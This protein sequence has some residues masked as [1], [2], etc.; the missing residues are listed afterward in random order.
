MNFKIL[1]LLST[2]CTVLFSCTDKNGLEVS[3]YVRYEAEALEN[4][5]VNVF[6]DVI[7]QTSMNKDD[8]SKFYCKE[9]FCE[10]FGPYHSG[11]RLLIKV[12]TPHLDTY[13]VKI[14]VRGSRQ[15]N[16]QLVDQG[17]NQGYY[18]LP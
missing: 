11:D 14:Y 5:D 2:V 4:V 13:I 15:E 17:W 3:Y 7:V 10:E 9:R 16:F 6:H 18:E 12:D 1:A 8:V